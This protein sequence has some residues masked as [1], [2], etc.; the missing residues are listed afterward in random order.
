MSRKN[1]TKTAFPLT[2][3]FRAIALQPLLF[4]AGLFPVPAAAYKIR[5]GRAEATG[6]LDRGKR[7]AGY[8][9]LSSLANRSRNFFSVPSSN[10][11]RQV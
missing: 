6:R 3:D 1:K 7:P 9:I 8:R 10:R 11:T 2:G 4:R 5:R